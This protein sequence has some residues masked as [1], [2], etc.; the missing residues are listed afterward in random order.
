MK[1]GYLGPKGTFSHEAAIKYDSDM[2]YVEYNTLYETVQA[3][4]NNEVD[5][6]IVPIENSIQGGVRD[7]LDSLIE[8]ENIF[9]KKEIILKIN[10]NLLVSKETNKENIKT[11]YS[12]PQAL[13]Q[14]KK[15]LIDNFKNVKLV[16]V[17]STAFS[18]KK[19]IGKAEV[20]A[21]ANKACATEYGLKILEENIQDNDFNETKFWVI[22]RKKNNTGN[23]MSLVFST[24]DTPGALYKVLRI[25]Y[26]ND[27]N[28][29]K[30]ESRPAKT[31]LG[32]Y[33]FLI[34]LEI[35]KYIE[36]ALKDLKEECK[37]I[38]ILGIY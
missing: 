17:S 25:F 16:E 11:I 37:F 5:E 21:I 32:E 1:L 20:A 31:V 26:S 4:S 35:N 29:T 3:I 2:E 36:I 28:L 15:Y 6:I 27:I 33:I 19:I 23:K 34:D 22:S 30:I 14:C 9:I 24:K 38:K 10:Q 12:H 13:A 8:T 7:V 18:A